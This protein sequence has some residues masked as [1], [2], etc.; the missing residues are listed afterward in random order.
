VVLSVFCGALLWVHSQKRICLTVDI[1]NEISIYGASMWYA[2]QAFREEQDR[3][4]QDTV[5]QFLCKKGY[6]KKMIP[7]PTYKQT[8]L[9][10]GF[11]CRQTVIQTDFLFFLN[12]NNWHDS[13]EIIFFIF[14]CLCSFLFL[15]FLK[16][17]NVV[18]FYVVCVVNCL[19]F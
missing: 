12:S 2:Q 16:C 15:L 14:F 11:Y 3:V 4:D 10:K 5:Y 7:S 1:F 8:W 17:C 9:F 6:E 19:C 13:S 18:L